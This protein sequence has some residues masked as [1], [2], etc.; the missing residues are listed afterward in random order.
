M[1]FLSHN[2]TSIS[3][4]I[5]RNQVNFSAARPGASEALGPAAESQAATGEED[6]RPPQGE[7][8]HDILTISSTE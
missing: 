3:G 5:P 4:E 6:W 2:I 8:W 1:G 7:T